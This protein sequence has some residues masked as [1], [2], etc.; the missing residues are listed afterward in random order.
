MVAICG[1]FCNPEG[2]KKEV[3]FPGILKKNPRGISMGLGFLP[4]NSQGMSC[5]IA[6]FTVMKD[7]FV[8]NF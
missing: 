6:K 1:C 4:W 2:V 3:E 5:T 8:W 7:C